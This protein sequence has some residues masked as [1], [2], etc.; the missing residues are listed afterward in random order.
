MNILLM[1]LRIS[2]VVLVIASCLFTS[3]LL[4]GGMRLIFKFIKE[5]DIKNNRENEQKN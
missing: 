4:V 1:I 3:Y 5:N 2:F